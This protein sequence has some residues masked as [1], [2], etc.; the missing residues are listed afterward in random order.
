MPILPIGSPRAGECSGGI[1]SRKPV[2][3][4]QT[5]P[6]LETLPVKPDN[7]FAM[8]CGFFKPNYTQPLPVGGS[9]IDIGSAATTRHLRLICPLVGG[10][11]QRRNLNDLLTSPVVITRTFCAAMTLPR[12]LGL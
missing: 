12:R 8:I 9:V 5:E 3:S 10:K 7:Q 2:L 4:L 6:K 11:I 1:P